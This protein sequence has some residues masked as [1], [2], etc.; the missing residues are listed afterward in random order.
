MAVE[1]DVWGSLVPIGVSSIAFSN[2]HS[3]EMVHSS[4]IFFILTQTS[5]GTFYFF[6]YILS[7]RVYRPRMIKRVYGCLGQMNSQGNG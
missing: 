7:A 1:F 6:V 5:A 3:L 4:G 2:I